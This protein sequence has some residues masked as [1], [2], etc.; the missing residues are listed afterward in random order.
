MQ[1]PCCKVW[2]P[3]RSR[4]SPCEPL[5]LL[6][7]MLDESKGDPPLYLETQQNKCL[8][9]GSVRFLFAKHC[10]V[11]EKHLYQVPSKFPFNIWPNDIIGH[12]SN[13]TLL[14]VCKN[15]Y[16]SWTLLFCVFFPTFCFW[17]HCIW[18]MHRRRCGLGIQWMW[19]QKCQALD[20]RKKLCCDIGSGSMYATKVFT[21]HSIYGVYLWYIYCRIMS[22]SEALG[23]SAAAG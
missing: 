12:K 21:V 23:F 3:K 19:S 22:F 5:C 13:N 15:Q 11:H 2:F 20:M 18:A 4:F 17:K 9:G 16:Y 7:L 14:V 6:N 1:L 8:L 10:K